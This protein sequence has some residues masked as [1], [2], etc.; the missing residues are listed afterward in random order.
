MS[1]DA[2]PLNLEAV[3][4]TRFKAPARAKAKIVNAYTVYAHYL[5]AV[6]EGCTPAAGSRQF[7]TD[8]HKVHREVTGGAGKMNLSGV[9]DYLWNCNIIVL[10]LRD[11]GAFHG[12]V[13]KIR[14]RYVIVLKQNTELEA[15]WL[16]DLLHEVGHIARGHLAEDGDLIE[17]NEIA[18][19]DRESEEGEAN[20][21]AVDALFDGDVEEVEDAVVHSCRADTR[22]L[23]AVIPKIAEQFRVDVGVLANHI[24]YK[25]DSEGQNWWATAH[26]L[27][28]GGNDP[29]EITRAALLARVRFQD[30]NLFDRELLLRAL[31]DV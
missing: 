16:Y 14:G 27:Q 9:L 24:A 12:A 15:R 5:A 7:S 17:A 10:P 30:L 22:R 8:W 21:W 26:V 31:S 25:M 3:A 4:A 13:W 6:I 2:P 23:K 1:F 28:Q 18:Q 29:F 19:G 20:A 11:S